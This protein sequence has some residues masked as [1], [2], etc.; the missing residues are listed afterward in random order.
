MDASTRRK[1]WSMGLVMLSIVVLS[2]VLSS[3]LINDLFEKDL[4]RKPFFITY[5][6]TATF[7]FYLIPYVKNVVTQYLEKGEIEYKEVEEEFIHPSSDEEISL[8]H[9]HVDDRLLLK[10]TIT[11]SAQFCIVWYLA[12][13]C[14]NASLSYTS[15]GS[16][17][18][19][20]STSSFFTLLVGSLAN[21]ER[22]NGIK[23]FGLAL[24]F[25]GVILVTKSDSE[26]VSGDLQRTT[27]SIF[28]GNTL[29]LLGALL[30]G[31]YTTMLKYRIRDESRV[32]MKVFLGFVGVFNLILLWPSLVVFHYTG[33]EVFEWPHGKFVVAIIVLNCLIT[34]ISDFCWVKATLLTSPLTVT[35]GLST[36]IPFAMVGDILFKDEKISLTYVVAALMICI[37]FFVIN[38]DAESD[39][40]VE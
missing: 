12:N 30:Y 38:R 39:R 24:S 9:N 20:S 33:V 17:T 40:H 13:L 29:A 5:I 28:V 11:L 16:Q 14:T 19:L 34:F 35:V 2:W 8:T 6:N 15:V 21:T 22:F 18:I 32:N 27:M 3:F 37:S 26:S 7:M 31:V 4:Y 10:E 36:T 23:V 25:V 1:R